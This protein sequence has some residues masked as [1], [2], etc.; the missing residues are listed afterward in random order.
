MKLCKYCDTVYNLEKFIGVE[1]VDNS[2]DKS[3]VISILFRFEGDYL[4]STDEDSTPYSFCISMSTSSLQITTRCKCED[5]ESAYEDSIHN[6]LEGLASEFVEIFSEKLEEMT[7][8]DNY[9]IDIGKI[10]RDIMKKVTTVVKNE[11]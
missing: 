9:T 11:N 10:K 6:V 3:D 8:E 2:D 7:V 4:H 5:I 1:V